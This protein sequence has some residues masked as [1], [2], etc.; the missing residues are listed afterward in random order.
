MCIEGNVWSVAGTRLVTWGGMKNDSMLWLAPSW[1][2]AG[3]P[4]GAANRPASSLERQRCRNALGHAFS[5]QPL[6]GLKL[7]SLPPCSTEGSWI[8]PD[9]FPKCSLPVMEKPCKVSGARR[10][11][12][13]ALKKHGDGRAARD[14]SL[15]AKMTR[16]GLTA[17]LDELAELLLTEQQ[18]SLL[19]RQ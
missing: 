9:S 8:K 16:V 1:A 17:S 18:K 14:H 3:F 15:K 4:S 10:K 5:L 19:E 13:D 11:I 6:Q 12:A 2:G 7:Q